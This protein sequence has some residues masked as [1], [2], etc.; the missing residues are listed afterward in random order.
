MKFTSWISK[1]LLAA[2]FLSLTGCQQ[3]APSSPRSNSPVALKVEYRQQ[4]IGIDVTAPRFSWQMQSAEQVRGQRQQAY[5]ITVTNEQ[6]Q[7]VWDSG[8]VISDAS[9]H[10]G[11]E[12]K[13]LLPRTRYT[14]TVTLWDQNNQPSSTTSW[15]ETGLMDTTAKAWHGAKWIGGTDADLPLFSDYLPLF[16]IETDLQIAKGSNQAG[17][18]FAAND[19]RMMDKFKNIYQVV[20]QEDQSYFKV[21]LDV[22]PLLNEKPAQLHFYRAGYTPNDDPTKPIR[23]VAIK[24]SVINKDNMYAYHHLAINN[25]FGSVTVQIDHQADFWVDADSYDPNPFEIMFGAPLKGV[26]VQLNPL[27]PNHDYI[28]YGM[29]NEFGFAVAKGNRASYKNFTVRNMHAP[30]AVLYQAKPTSPDN[31]IYAAYG[32][33]LTSSENSYVVGSENQDSFIVAKPDKIGMPLLRSDF[34]VADKPIA[35]ARLYVTARGIYEFYI[36]GQQISNDYYNPG[37]TQ[38]NKTH[39]YQTYDVTASLSTGDN[40]MGAQLAEGW[41]SGLLGFGNTWNGFGDRQSLLAQLIITYDDGSEDVITTQPDSWQFSTN[42]P[43]RYGSLAMGE[44]Y[45]AR[46]A[47]QQKNWATVNYQQQWQN[48]SEVPLAS[49]ISKNVQPNMMFPPQSL[50]YDGMQLVGQ[51]DKPASVYTTL[52]AKSVEQVRPGVFVY[53]LGQNMVGVPKI[54][55][56]NGEEGQQITLRYAEML[57]PDLPESGPNV[58]MIMTENYRAALSQDIYIMREGKQ[59]FQPRFTSHGFQYIEITGIDE[60][61]PLDQVQ[62]VVV[63]SVNQLTAQYASSSQQVNQLW[64]NL[65]WSNIDNFQWVPTDCPQRNE[66]MG[67]SGDINV[68]APTATYVSNTSQFMRRHLLSMRD[69][70]AAN[71]RFTDVA[72]VGGGFGGI[73]WGVAG[74]TIPWETYQQYADVGL[75]TEHYHS[76]QDYLAYLATTIDKDTGLS[77][78]AGLGDWLGPQNNQLGS[79]YLA[80]AYHIYA[81]NIMQQVATVLGH[82]DDAG[83]YQ[84]QLEERRAFFNHKFVNADK[85]TMGILGKGSPFAPGDGN[86]RD[87]IADTQTSFAVGLAMNAFDDKFDDYMAKQLA[88]AVAAKNTDDSGVERPSYSLMTGFIG[89]AWISKALS[90][91]GYTDE[92]YRLLLNDSYPSWLYSIN[93][94]ATTIWERL[95][96]YTVENGFGGNNSMNSFNHYSFGAVGEWL[97]SRSG[98]IRRDAPGFKSFILQPEIDPQHQINWVNASYDSMYGHIESKWQVKDGKLTYQATVPP[99]TTATLI[100]PVDAM[101]LTESGIPLSDSKGIDNVSGTATQTTMTL[102]SGSYSFTATLQ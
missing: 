24:Q 7:S 36:N 102:G 92:A 60:A 52:T 30:N 79:D 89:T 54:T 74:I 2:A 95:N 70:Q 62:G 28:T 23:S 94:G 10:I 33:Q 35:K 65:V 91:N 34:A 72:P 59:V 50:S 46:I 47:E 76:M 45:D 84:S 43:V 98:G 78:E 22:S 20:N 6:G 80:T 85:H 15:F 19:P 63:S 90:D 61:L 77:S 40:A 82:T 75:L 99:N 37:L 17:V 18:V 44:V 32:N 9:L 51:I 101:H 13:P 29:L 88:A 73:L 58:G 81:L 93:Q 25:S 4:P 66:R 21:S 31:D 14:W 64:S 3:G 67:W 39:M 11:Y 5:S 69:T 87:E 55:F 38:Y 57:Y 97:I 71:G 48:A 86:I 42:S 26:T 83:V 96:G 8:K 41:W 68:F 56:N 12:G 1:S 27:G 100:L 49:S 53:N 16:L